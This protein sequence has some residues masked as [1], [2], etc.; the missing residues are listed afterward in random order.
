MDAS[1]EVQGSFLPPDTQTGGVHEWEYLTDT[2]EYNISSVFD[3]TPFD[4]RR[5]SDKRTRDFRIPGEAE[6]RTSN[7][8]TDSTKWVIKAPDSE[9]EWREDRAP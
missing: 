7:Y 8:L 3:G 5:V 2:Q 9:F 6:G 4:L 1:Q